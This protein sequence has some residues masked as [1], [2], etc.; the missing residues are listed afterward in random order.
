VVSPLLYLRM[1]LRGK[2]LRGVHF[3]S[4]SEAGVMRWYARARCILDLPNNLQS[5]YTMRT[6]EALGAHRKLITTNQRIKEEHFYTPQTVFVTE[7]GVF[8]DKAFLHSPANVSP[9]L[10]QYSLRTWIVRLLCDPDGKT[11]IFTRT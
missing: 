2:M 7:G 11:H 9:E 5:G 1:L 4:L 8:P 3:K 10:E 6:F